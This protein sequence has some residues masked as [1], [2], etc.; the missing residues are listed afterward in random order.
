M[1]LDRKPS[2][3]FDRG[4]IG[5]ADEL[6]AYGV[7]VKSEPQDMAATLAGVA[8]FGDET[9][10]YGADFDSDFDN[11]GT[12][13]L[14]LSDLGD[15]IPVF[16]TGAFSSDDFDDESFDDEPD[17]DI[18]QGAQGEMSNQLLMKIAG[19]LSSIRSELS[20]LKEEFAGIRA[21]SASGN[22]DDGG[23][24][25][26]FFRE[27]DDE[28]IALTGDEMSGILNTAGFSAGDDFAFDPL[29]DEDEAALS[30]LAQRE[31]TSGFN[32]PQDG[33]EINIDFDA[34]GINLDSISEEDMPPPGEIP[35]PEEFAGDAAGAVLPDETGE[36][37]NLRL[38]G[39]ASI[40]PPPDSIGYLEEDP[41]AADISLDT[42]DFAADTPVLLDEEDS[43]D[44]V[45]DSIAL[46]LS[47]TVID[48]SDFSVGA[49]AEEPALDELLDSI[50]GFDSMDDSGGTDNSLAQV[51]PEGFEIGAEEA[52]VPFD[53]DLE[54]FAEE[55]IAIDGTEAAVPADE[56]VKADAAVKT[57]GGGAP[58]KA[59]NTHAE[60]PNIPPEIRGDLKN[61]LS[62]MDRLLESLPDEKIEEFAKSKH[63]DTYKKLFK[64]LGL[65]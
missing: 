39:A 35:Q 25:G 11:L 37:Q 62:Y 27:D 34:L 61:V 13:G 59:R 42:G 56:S 55:D 52:A 46:D 10:S 15:E 8:G 63:F 38:E 47:E 19:E 18:E 51:I 57:D 14:D 65:S 54:A 40:V 23:L 41:F 30:M 24:A 33:E 26:G 64:E 9:L 48:D 21:E 2:M 16:E 22:K 1:A 20:T 31:E 5:S 6:D 32:M 3:Y 53:D 7:W 60:S 4:T 49:P 58:S 17:E 45:F 50:E 43:D 36:L 12:S 44:T 29:R 28:K